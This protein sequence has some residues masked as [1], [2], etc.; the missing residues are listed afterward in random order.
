MS[1]LLKSTDPRTRGAAAKGKGRRQSP[2]GGRES[3]RP[4]ERSCGPI[5]VPPGPP[6]PGGSCEAK[7]RRVTVVSHL[8]QP[9][10]DDAELVEQILQGSSAHF[11][12]LYEA[13]FPRVYRFALKRLRDAAEA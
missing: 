6:R 8:E 1:P 7:R 10:T 4:V 2:A 12:M 13:Y 11:D 3:S 5:W 9:W